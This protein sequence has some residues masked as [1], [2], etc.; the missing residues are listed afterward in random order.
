MEDRL[1]GRRL[2][3]HLISLRME[4][5]H[6]SKRV[7]LQMYGWLVMHEDT[8]DSNV[9]KDSQLLSDRWGVFFKIDDYKTLRLNP[10]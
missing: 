5:P 10:E 7:P 8:A 6:S 2:S 3:N 9:F 4:T 1:D